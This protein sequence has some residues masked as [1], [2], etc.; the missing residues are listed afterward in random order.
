[1]LSLSQ[2]HTGPVTSVQLHS[3]P[4]GGALLISTGGDAKTCIWD[5]LHNAAASGAGEAAMRDPLSF[6]SDALRQ[7]PS[8]RDQMRM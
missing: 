5:G 1:M 3:L 8:P 4:D 6:E 7:Q 2:G